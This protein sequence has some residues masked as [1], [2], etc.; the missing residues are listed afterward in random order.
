MGNKKMV[1][2][3]VWL[4]IL[5]GGFVYYHVV[6]LRSIFPCSGIGG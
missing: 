5:G 2:W 1:V 6:V 3:K 4:G